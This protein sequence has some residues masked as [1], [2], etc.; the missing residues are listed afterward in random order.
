MQTLLPDAGEFAAAAAE[1]KSQKRMDEKRLRK[2][3]KLGDPQPQK[4]SS[5][6]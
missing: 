2:Q 5:L 1:R 4:A 6:W 3:G